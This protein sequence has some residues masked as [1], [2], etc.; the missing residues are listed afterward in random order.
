[1]LFFL[2]RKA[3]VLSFPKEKICRF[4]TD[5]KTTK[6]VVEAAASNSHT[7][8]GKHIHTAPNRRNRAPTCALRHSPRGKFVQLESPRP[9]AQSYRLHLL[10]VRRVP[11]WIARVYEC[12]HVSG[13]DEMRFRF[14]QTV[15]RNVRGFFSFFSCAYK[16]RTR[17]SFPKE[18]RKY[19]V[20]RKSHGNHHKQTK[21]RGHRRGEA[22]G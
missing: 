19:K 21:S 15:E 11:P 18:K 7:S 2:Q 16:K 12:K 17:F 6:R 13:A 4:L 14:A 10:P 8:T 22:R 3:C 5:E 9:Q 20:K 1:M